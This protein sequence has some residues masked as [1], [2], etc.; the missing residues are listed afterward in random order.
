MHRADE[1]AAHIRDEGAGC[2]E[3]AGMSGTITLRM[4]IS[5]AASKPL[6]RSGAAEGKEHEIAVVDTFAGEQRH[7][8]RIDVRGGDANDVLGRLLST[9]AQP[10][11]ERADRGIRER[12]VDTD[13]TIRN[14]P[15]RT[16]PSRR[17]KRR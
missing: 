11:G 17:H 9:A 5:R 2:G 4:P 14:S 12:L 7:E 1:I 15:A 3:D 10:L 6:H 13:A 8:R 16:I